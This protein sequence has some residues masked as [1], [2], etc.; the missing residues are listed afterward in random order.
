MN[1]LL[2]LTI[3]GVEQWVLLR[4][5]PT[6]RPN[7]LLLVVQAGPGLPLI[8]EAGVFQRTLRLE[9]DFV[10]AYW[11]Q[12][13]CGKSF[14]NHLSPQ[15]MTLEQLVEDTA[16]VLQALTRHVGARVANLLGFSQG[17]AVAA[18]TAGRYPELVRSLVT[19]GMDIDYAAAE[20]DAYA[21]AMQRARD[22]GHSRALRELAAI[23]PPPHADL[24]RF[25][26]RVKWLADFGGVH[27]RETYNSLFAKTLWRL[28]VAPQYSPREIV[29]ALRGIQFSRRYLLP[30][31]AGIDLRHQLPRLDVPTFM[32]QGRH[33]HAAPESVAAC[34]ADLLVAPAGKWLIW[35]EDSAHMPHLEEP[36]RF[37]EV[38]LEMKQLSQ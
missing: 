30:S 29:G 28:L 3:G 19:V 12:R 27:R 33:D 31:L 24:K 11:D 16:E 6:S 8:N 32:V 5:R 23:G 34:Y 25:G 38:L 26:V 17:G 20:E 15:S 36:R 7:P 18:L 14:G 9:D 10:V 13:A 2:K 1:E 21:F 37:R 22:L 4:G 35:F